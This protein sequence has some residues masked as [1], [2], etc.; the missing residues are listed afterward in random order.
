MA[1]E[2]VARIKSA[3]IIVL[4]MIIVWAG[5]RLVGR[6]LAEVDPAVRCIMDIEEARLFYSRIGLSRCAAFARAIDEATTKPNTPCPAPK[7][8]PPAACGIYADYLREAGCAPPQCR[9]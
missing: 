8:T 4:V 1:G 3:L 2:E 6:I 5:I 7:G 9:A